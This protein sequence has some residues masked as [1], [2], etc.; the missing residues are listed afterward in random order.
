[1]AFLPSGDLVTGDGG[2]A[3]R[4]WATGSGRLRVARSSAHTSQIMGV[5]ASPDGKLVATVAADGSARLWDAKSLTPRTGPLAT[6]A[7]GGGDVAFTPDGDR[8]VVASGRAITVW[9]TRGERID[10]VEAAD[11]V[12]WGVAVSPDGAHV[13]TASADRT[14]A[15]RPLDDLDSVEHRLGHSGVATDVAFSADSQTLVTTSRSGELRFWDRGTGELLGEPFA[16][17]A[18]RI[19]EVWRLA[20]D[21]LHSH[22][23]FAGGDGDV[24]ETDVLD[25]QAGCRLAAGLL[26]LRQRERFLGGEP[27][28]GCR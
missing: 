1:M 4:R 28:I 20:Y 21:P 6:G 7:A 5:A 14:V 13:A 3:L 26:D 10:R 19:G 16:R 22:V 15:V 9:T 12:I 17:A 2:G 18:T 11:D 24:R 23:W 25:L 8:L 27:A